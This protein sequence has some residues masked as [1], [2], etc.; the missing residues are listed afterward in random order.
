MK[1]QKLDRIK[2]SLQPSNHPYLNG[3]WTPQHEEVNATDLR[4]LEGAIP[5]EISGV[6]LRNTENQV[7]EPG[8]GL[9]ELH[10]AIIPLQKRFWDFEHRSQHLKVRRMQAG[11]FKAK[12]F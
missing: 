8:F 10:D 3:A 12:Q 5:T 1:L 7:H 6:Y 9:G 4:I 11:E 2:S